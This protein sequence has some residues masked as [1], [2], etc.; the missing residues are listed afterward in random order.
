MILSCEGGF[1]Y[2]DGLCSMMRSVYLNAERGELSIVH[3]VAIHDAWLMFVLMCLW[4][5][6]EY[7]LPKLENTIALCKVVMS[8]HSWKCMLINVWIFEDMKV[9][10][11]QVY[12]ILVFNF[13][14]IYFIFVFRG[15]TDL[16]FYYWAF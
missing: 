2:S 6:N 7:L 3:I 1:S 5:W 13:H 9:C 11:I 14:D 15:V 4:C 16:A 10:T 8:L 12:Y